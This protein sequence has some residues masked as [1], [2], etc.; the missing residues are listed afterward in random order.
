MFPVKVG[1][2]NSPKPF[3]IL[4]PIYNRVEVIETVY[5]V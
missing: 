3:V 2:V 5:F 4:I 1:V